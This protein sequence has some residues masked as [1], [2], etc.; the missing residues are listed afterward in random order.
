MRARYVP[1]GAILELWSKRD[2]GFLAKL[3]LARLLGERF[4][5]LL[6]QLS[7]RFLRLCTPPQNPHKYVSTILTCYLL[8]FLSCTYVCMYASMLIHCTKNQRCK[9]IRVIGKWFAFSSITPRVNST[10]SFDT[11]WKYSLTFTAHILSQPS[12]YSRNALISGTLNGIWIGDSSR[13]RP[14]LDVKERPHLLSL[15]MDIVYDRESSSRRSEPYSPICYKWYKFPA[16]A[17]HVANLLISDMFNGSLLPLLV[18]YLSS[19]LLYD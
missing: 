18:N 12:I 10:H 7:D 4:F 1:F 3:H 2:Q 15:R 5:K 17:P 19:R 16:R 9:H 6:E 13:N 8:C 11:S 14:I